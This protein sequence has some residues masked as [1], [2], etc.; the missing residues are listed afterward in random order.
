MTWNDA[1]AYC[2]WLSDQEGE[3]Y[4]L[5]TEVEWEYACRAASAMRRSFGNDEHEL[6]RHAWVRSNS[7]LAPQPVGRK[8]PNRF[9]LRDMHGNVM[10]WCEDLYHKASHHQTRG[11]HPTEFTGAPDDRGRALR[12]GSV[13]AAPLGCRSAWRLVSDPSDRGNHWG[14]RVVRTA[15]HT[16]SPQLSLTVTRVPESDPSNE[17]TGRS[18]K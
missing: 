9:G 12:G 10:E 8:L 4:R 6:P 13:W 5:P 7:Q 1:V 2:Q 17:C 14:F 18:K 16:S 3:E 11:H 15:R